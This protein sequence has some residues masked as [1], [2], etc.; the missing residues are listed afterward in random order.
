MPPENPA[1]P[2]EASF[3]RA[4]K[5]V[6]ALERGELPLDDCLKEYELGYQALKRCYEILQE[7]QKRIEV[8]AGPP[9]GGASVVP[10]WKPAASVQPLGE[11]LERLARE[12]A[13]TASP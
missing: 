11:A 2:F 7:A 4:E 10:A 3:A 8:L 1:M 5:A 12:Q 6:A 13:G 9:P